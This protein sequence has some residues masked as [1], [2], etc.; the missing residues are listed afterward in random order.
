MQIYSFVYFIGWMASDP[1]KHECPR[2]VEEEVESHVP[3]HSQEW[4]KR[5]ESS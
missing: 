5:E 1:S 2:H 4:D 3:V